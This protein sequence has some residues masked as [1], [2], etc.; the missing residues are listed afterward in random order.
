[1][2]LDTKKKIAHLEAVNAMALETI[3]QIKDALSDNVS[4]EIDDVQDEIIARIEQ[5]I[6][7]FDKYN[8]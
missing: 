1:M 8:K 7:W 4:R 3:K 2:D 5:S 6:K